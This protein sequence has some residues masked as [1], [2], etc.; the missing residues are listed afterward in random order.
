MSE[1]IIIVSGGT[2][3]LGKAVVEKLSSENNKIYL[4]VRSLDKF[5]KMYDSSSDESAEYIPRK[6]YAL[7]CDLSKYDEIK[8][9]VDSVAGMEN[10]RID[11][12][13]NLAGGIHPP[14]ELSGI[15]EKF[16]DEYFKLNFESSLFLSTSVLKYMKENQCGSI[17]FTGALAGLKMM[18]GRYVYSAGK[19]ALIN[20][21]ES[22]ALEM[23]QY[24]IRCN[25][26]M[27]SVLDTKENREWASEEEAKKFVSTSEVADAISGLL[28]DKYKSLN[29]T[30]LKLTGNY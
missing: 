22:I 2:G 3:N 25:M 8:N 19:A 21:M 24:N 20:L 16:F 28:S 13:V 5:R 23:K 1:K 30:I 4:P 15:D 18:K 7:E 29:Q 27:P 17:I 14:V 9:F 12:L 10:G 26:V 11:A 6:I